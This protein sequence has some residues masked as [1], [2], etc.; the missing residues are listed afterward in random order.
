MKCPYFL[1]AIQQ[2]RKKIII[3]ASADVIHRLTESDSWSL[4]DTETG[5]VTDSND[6]VAVQVKVQWLYSLNNS[7]NKR[8]KARNATLI[9]E[10]KG[11]TTYLSNPGEPDEE[12]KKFTF[13]FS[14]WSHDG[15]EEK[16][17]GYLAPS[18]PRYADQVQRKY[19]MDFLVFQIREGS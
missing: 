11:Q 4:C 12:A 15:F 7:H 10:M 2:C 19:N 17:D 6:Y 18:D 1:T 8:E 3:K 5:H 16:P 13:D 14:Y 9:V